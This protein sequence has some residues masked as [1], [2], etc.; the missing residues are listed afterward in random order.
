MDSVVHPAVRYLQPEQMYPSSDLK[1]MPRNMTVLNYGASHDTQTSKGSFAHSVGNGRIDTASGTVDSSHDQ[2]PR[3]YSTPLSQPP[4]L[5]ES[6]G[7]AITPDI[8]SPARQQI[9][10][11]KRAAIVPL[12]DTLR[13]LQEEE[14]ALLHQLEVRRLNHYQDSL[15]K[16]IEERR[17]RVGILE[18][19][20][21]RTVSGSSNL[22]ANTGD[23]DSVASNGTPVSPARSL[24]S[25]LSSGKENLETVS[26]EYDNEP[27]KDSLVLARHQLA[28]LAL[29]STQ[30][31][32]HHNSIADSS[33]GSVKSPSLPSRP[34]EGSLR[35][36]FTAEESRLTSLGSPPTTPFSPRSAQGGFPHSLPPNTVTAGS[37]AAFHGVASAVSTGDAG[38]PA[39][40]PSNFSVSSSSSRALRTSAL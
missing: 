17:L 8:P 23:Q 20:L 22:D 37:S 9:Y 11:A 21:N 29:G 14:A 30:S 31:E 28:S 3:S 34:R 13:A 24:T 33:A 7:R 40:K 1:A 4:P 38:I 2:P 16:Q 25:F 32:G 39:P 26:D 10:E 19:E 27:S 36:A 18:H 15:S 12:E 6:Q 35:K 5:R